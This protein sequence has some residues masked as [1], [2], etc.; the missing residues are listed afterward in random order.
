MKGKERFF[1]A[2]EI[3]QSNQNH[4]TEQLKLYIQAKRPP[5]E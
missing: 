4:K 5:I 3:R 2:K 1:P